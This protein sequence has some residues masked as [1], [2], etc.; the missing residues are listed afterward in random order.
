MSQWAQSCCDIFFALGVFTTGLVRKGKRM[1]HSFPIFARL[2]D[3]C[4]HFDS[5]FLYSKRKLY[6]K[7][8]K[9]LF[10]ENNS[11]LEQN[12]LEE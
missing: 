7:L 2:Q 12:L 5:N 4:F 9:E 11:Y 3:Y 10:K 6:I 8:W 1:S